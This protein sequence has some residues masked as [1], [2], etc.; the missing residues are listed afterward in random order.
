[1]HCL[2]GY[3]GFLFTFMTFQIFKN[4]NQR[5]EYSLLPGQRSN[6]FFGLA[7]DYYPA[8]D[9]NRIRI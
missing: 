8:F 5:P 9:V 7:I 1:M 3:S 2:S 6:C 4:V